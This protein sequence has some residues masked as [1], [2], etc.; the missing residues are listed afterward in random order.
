M[1]KI[2]TITF[3]YEE[4][5]MCLNTDFAPTRK[6]KHRHKCL[7]AGKVI[8]KLWDEIPKWCPLEEK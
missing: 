4:C 2:E 7:K 1:T 8:P 3:E 5:G 6:N